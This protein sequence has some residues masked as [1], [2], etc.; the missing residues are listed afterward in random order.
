MEPVG[1]A[2]VVLDAGAEAAPALQMTPPGN[3]GATSDVIADVINGLG[4]LGSVGV[5]AGG[6]EGRGHPQF[7]R[8]HCPEKGEGLGLGGGAWGRKASQ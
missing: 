8:P 7:H 3:G 6:W 4:F 1:V 2:S 5:G